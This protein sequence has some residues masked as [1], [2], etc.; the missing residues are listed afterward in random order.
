MKLFKGIA[1]VTG[2][3]MGAQAFALPTF[4]QLATQANSAGGNINISSFD[5]TPIT[6][7]AFWTKLSGA[8]VKFKSEISG[9]NNAMGFANTDGTGGTIVLNE[10]DSGWKSLDAAPNPFVFY[11]NTQQGSEWFSDNSLNADGLDHMLAFQKKDGSDRFILFWD[12]QFGGGD[13]DF[14]D[15]VARVN[16]VSPVDVP[17]PGSLALLGLGLFALGLSR[18]KLNS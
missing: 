9:Y 6:D 1:L 14:N 2:L 18:R 7:D 12:D 15:F 4:N 17:E 5:H 16:F 8:A 13:R 11:L 3:L 10:G